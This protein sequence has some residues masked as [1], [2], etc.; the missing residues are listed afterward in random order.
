MLGNFTILVCMILRLQVLFVGN[1]VLNI[2]FVLCQ[3]INL[4][5]HLSNILTGVLL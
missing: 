5:F 4:T 1:L 2:S 3:G